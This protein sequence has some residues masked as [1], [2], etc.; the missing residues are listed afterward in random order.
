MSVWSS[1]KNFEARSNRSDTC[2]CYRDAVR[3]G[4]VLGRSQAAGRDAVRLGIALGRSQG[5]SDRNAVRLG[6]VLGRSQDAAISRHSSESRSGDD[7][8]AIVTMDVR[9]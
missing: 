4:I 1:W 9:T 6:I 8:E 3:L 5:P 7:A 2:A